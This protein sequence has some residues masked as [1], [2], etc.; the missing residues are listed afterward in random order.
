MT[1]H[2]F[3]PARTQDGKLLHYSPQPAPDLAAFICR[4]RG[5]TLPALACLLGSTHEEAYSALRG[6]PSA[7][8]LRRLRVIEASI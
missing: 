7:P 2:T 8:I 6:T 4:T 1:R 5:W 3:L